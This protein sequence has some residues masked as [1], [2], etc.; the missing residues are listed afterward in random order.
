MSATLRRLVEPFTGPVAN[1][2][3]ITWLPPVAQ[4]PELFVS[5]DEAIAARLACVLDA[6]RRGQPT[7]AFWQFQGIDSAVFGG[8]ST[9]PKGEVHTLHFDNFG[10]REALDLT[11]CLNP[12]L[13]HGPGI[14]I[15]CDNGIVALAPPELAQALT[16]LEHDVVVTAGP[17]HRG[18]ALKAARETES[19]SAA[20]HPGFLTQI[21]DTVQLAIQ[22]ATGTNWPMCPRHDRHPLEF[23]DHRWFCVLDGAFL[24]ELGG[25]AGIS[26]KPRPKP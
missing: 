26:V 19:G 18:V 5:M 12:R 14:Q 6:R 15:E 22:A 9:T 2:C 16:R 20:S 25:L 4:R 13:S 8:V 24:A 21:V 7:W 10:G 1:P 23:R 11:P 17:S 3:G